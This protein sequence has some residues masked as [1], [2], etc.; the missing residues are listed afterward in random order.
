MGRLIHRTGFKRMMIYSEII[1]MAGVVMWIFGRDPWIFVLASIP[2]GLTAA[3]WV[4]VHQ[5]LLANAV[6]AAERGRVV[7]KVS[8]FRTL[9]SFPAPFMGGLLFDWGG[10][11][12]PMI[13]NLVGAAFATVLIALLV[14][15]V[16]TREAELTPVPTPIPGRAR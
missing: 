15:D 10:F 13:A 4:P 7:G 14:V 16:P 2:G 8:A 1:G 12:A 3:T 9:L 5:T 11:Q 6:P